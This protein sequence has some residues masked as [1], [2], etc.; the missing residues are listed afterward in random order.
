MNERR[1]VRTSSK[2]VHARQ[3]NR[4][5]D[6]NTGDKNTG[7]K[8]TGDKNTGDKKTRFRWSKWSKRWKGSSSSQSAW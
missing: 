6:K 4:T 3:H 7:D 8:N 5:G 2:V 1:E